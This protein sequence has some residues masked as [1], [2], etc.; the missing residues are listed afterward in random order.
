MIHPSKLASLVSAP[1]KETIQTEFPS[2]N[3]MHVHASPQM[4]SIT[5]YLKHIEVPRVSSE[6]KGGSRCRAIV[7]EDVVCGEV[8]RGLN[9]KW[10]Q[11]KAS[12]QQSNTT[13]MKLPCERI[14]AVETMLQNEE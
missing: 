14:T 9:N 13:P 6:T 8:S 10:P 5:K 12:T 7:C 1:V 11:T 3:T 4:R 2:Y